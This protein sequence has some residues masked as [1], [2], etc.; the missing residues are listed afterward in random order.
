[1]CKSCDGA[2]NRICV[3]RF[4]LLSLFLLVCVPLPLF[5]PVCLSALCGLLFP[6]LTGSVS[7]SSSVVYGASFIFLCV[8]FC[9]AADVLVAV[10][11]AF[12]CRDCRCPFF[13]WPSKDLSFLSVCVC[14]IVVAC[15]YSV[16]LES[17]CELVGT[18]IGDRAERLQVDQES[19]SR[20]EKA[21]ALPFEPF[22]RRST[23]AR[24]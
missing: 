4:F 14:V 10:L 11:S 7:C 18:D 8:P 22:T 21:T 23:L 12:V 24:E 5:L 1:M 2:A 6:D 19:I 9:L 16:K 17:N 15:A 13:S 20:W 3:V